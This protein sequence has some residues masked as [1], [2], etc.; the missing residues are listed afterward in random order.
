MESYSIFAIV[1]TLYYARL[2]FLRLNVT[3]AFREFVLFIYSVNYLFSPALVYLLQDSG[4]VYKMRIPESEYFILTIPS[5]LLFHY[6]MF[7]G[8]SKLFNINLKSIKFGTYLNQQLLISWIILGVFLSVFAKYI[9]TS[10]AFIAY[11]LA[12][13]KYIAAYS[14]YIFD[15]RKYRYY[16][17][18]LLIFEISN[19]LFGG[20][21]GDLFLWFGFSAIFWCFL[22]KPTV[23]LKLLISVAVLILFVVIQS[24]KVDYRN[25]IWISGEDTGLASFSESATKQVNSDKLFSTEQTLFNLNRLNQGWIFASTVSNMN[26]SANF[27]GLSL[28]SLYVQS[29]FLPRFISP[30]KLQSGDKDIFNKFSGHYIGKGTSMGLGVFADGYIAYKSNGVYLFAFVLGLIFYTIFKI[31]ENWTK[32][33]PFFVMFL[34]PIFFYAVRPDCETQTLLGHIVKSLIVFGILVQVYKYYFL[35]S[36]LLYDQV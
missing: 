15:K 11:L 33:S 29:A 28:V 35:R 17:L 10:L 36:R 1:I 2:L 16:L 21:F 4:Y 30:D 8:S 23:K 25:K 6:G 5:I 24:S 13:L 26:R 31:V 34:Y 14:L 27:Q 3:L 19:A 20:M 7:V 12:M 18:G 9:P 32:I 22:E